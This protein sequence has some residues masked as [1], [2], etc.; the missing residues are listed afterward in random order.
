MAERALLIDSV[1]TIHT[2]I[3]ST[4]LIEAKR[5][6]SLDLQMLKL[7]KKSAF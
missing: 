6:L 3:A 4:T 5:V 2:H 7:Q 1:M